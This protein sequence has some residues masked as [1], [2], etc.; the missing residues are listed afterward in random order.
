[1]NQLRSNALWLLSRGLYSSLAE[2]I[3]TGPGDDGST[4]ALIVVNPTSTLISGG[5]LFPVDMPWP[6][7]QPFPPIVIRDL[8]SGRR[9]LH[10]ISGTHWCDLPEADPMR[11]QGRER[12]RFLLTLQVVDIP[13][14]GYA[15]FIASFAGDSPD[16]PV[17]D[18]GPIRQDLAV[19]ETLRHDG[20]L[21]PSSSLA[22]A[23][24]RSLNVRIEQ[25][26]PDESNMIFVAVTNNS[27]TAS[28]NNRLLFNAPVKQVSR[29]GHT[30]APLAPI[31]ASSTQ[32]L[33]RIGAGETIRLAV[34]IAE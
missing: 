25:V 29:V 2:R 10:E 27:R 7:A 22:I 17:L 6:A 16:L 30:L 14:L 1:M 32:H 34:S 21:Q 19:V 8:R 5:A 13:I 33:P 20:E 23:D 28:I 11:K 3:N 9:I 12:L 26:A 31:E 15:T 4:R 18:I 24:D